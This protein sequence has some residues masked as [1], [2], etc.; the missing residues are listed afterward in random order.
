MMI[1]SPAGLFNTEIDIT[2]KNISSL[3]LVTMRFKS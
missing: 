2:F 3:L 1:K